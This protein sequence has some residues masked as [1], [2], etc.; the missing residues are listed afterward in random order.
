MSGSLAQI[1]AELASA[2]KAWEEGN[3][4]Q[5]RVC[6]RRAVSRALTH[7]RIRRGE[8][9]LPGDTLAHLRWIQQQTQFPREVVLAAQRLS[10]KVTERDRA[11]FSIDPIADARL[12]IDALLSTAM[13]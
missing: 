10:T 1:K 12:I 5:A 6:A 11:P 2:R 3:E 9:P 4:G 8:P 13:P 7:W